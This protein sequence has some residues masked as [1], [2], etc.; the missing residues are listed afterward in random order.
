MHRRRARPGRDAHRRALLA[1]SQ[2]TEGRERWVRDGRPGDRVL[3]P[4]RGDGPRS[5][6]RARAH[7]RDGHRTTPSRRGGRRV[8]RTEGRRPPSRRRR[9]H[10]RAPHPLRGASNL[11]RGEPRVLLA[12]RR[13]NIPVRPSR[14]VPQG[15]RHRRARSRARGRGG[16]PH[17]RHGPRLGV[18]P[19]IRRPARFTIFRPPRRR[20]VRRAGLHRQ[21]QLG[22]PCIPRAG[23]R[24]GLEDLRASP[25]GKRSGD[26]DVLALRGEEREGGGDPTGRQGGGASGGDVERWTFVFLPRARTCAW[27][28]R[29]ARGRGEPGGSDG[30]D[31]RGWRK[32][33]GGDRTSRGGGARRR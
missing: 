33:R 27:D 20:G 11:H 4:S 29:D 8:L 15:R 22:Q 2:V 9:H 24:A 25:A 10:P 18:R 31:S 32:R 26:G 13:R 19:P 6:P 3:A 12:A 1:P 16:A 23:R 7:H 28:A 5:R 30:A 21:R 17:G 14:G